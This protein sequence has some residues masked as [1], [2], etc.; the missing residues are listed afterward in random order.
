MPI[1]VTL[2]ATTKG[3][4]TKAKFNQYGV[5]LFNLL[6]RPNLLIIDSH[7][8]HMYKVAFY[9]EMKEHNVH[10]LAIPPH[11]SY[12]VQALDSTPLV[13]FKSAWQRK[14]LYWVFHTRAKNLSIKNF[15]DV[16]WPAFH[17]SMTVAKIQSVFIPLGYF[18]LILM[19]LIKPNLH[20]H[21][22]LT[23][24]IIESF[25]MHL[26]IGYKC[27][28]LSFI[29]CTLFWYLIFLLKDIQVKW[30]LFKIFFTFLG[31][32]V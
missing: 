17:D 1:S 15:F 32:P 2:A 6:N 7:K 8:S 11:T 23:V 30:Q 26:C 27:C 22:L 13:Q 4:T 12:L 5:H 14:L 18:L 9:E 3:Y 24:R 28:A 19:L 31:T 25:C 20:Q 16:F 21:K 29:M 10:A